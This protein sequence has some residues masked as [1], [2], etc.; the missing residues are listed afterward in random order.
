MNSSLKRS[1][2]AFRP[3]A[4]LPTS[5][6]N[7]NC[8]ESQIVSKIDSIITSLKDLEGNFSKIKEELLKKKTIEG[9]ENGKICAVQGKV[10]SNQKKYYKSLEEDIDSLSK[11]FKDQFTR[12][13]SD[14]SCLQ[15]ISKGRPEV[16]AGSSGENLFGEAESVY[17]PIKCPGIQTIKVIKNDDQKDRKTMIPYTLKVSPTQTGKMTKMSSQIEAM[18]ERIIGKPRSFTQTPARFTSSSLPQGNALIL[19]C[20]PVVGRDLPLSEGVLGFDS[21]YGSPQDYSANSL[22][23]SLSDSQEN[24]EEMNKSRGYGYNSQIEDGDKYWMESQIDIRF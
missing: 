15:S 7:I 22:S 3:D 18:R 20:S 17:T 16:Q 1:E 8:V 11:A 19:D 4:S 13:T 9:R 6:R 14:L 2:I 23:D 24:E 21:K 5:A 12:I 10:V